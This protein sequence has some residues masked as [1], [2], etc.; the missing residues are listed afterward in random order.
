MFPIQVMNSLCY[1]S[2]KQTDSLRATREP[3]SSQ[4]LHPVVVVFSWCSISSQAGLKKKIHPLGSA[5]AGDSDTAALAAL[6]A[7]DPALRPAHPPTTGAPGQPSASK[8]S[9]ATGNKP[10]QPTKS[11]SAQP[12][13]TTTGQSVAG[14]NSQP[15]HN[16][17]AQPGEQGGQSQRPKQPPLSGASDAHDAGGDTP[18]SQQQQQQQ[19]Q[20]PASPGTIY[21][22]LVQVHLH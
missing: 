7:S 2:N 11:T 3:I 19:Q 6:E 14:R 21:P 18:L 15:P 9:P 16:G 17:D 8:P 13:E 5:A 22:P 12:A 10:G 20:Q 1:N 4:Q